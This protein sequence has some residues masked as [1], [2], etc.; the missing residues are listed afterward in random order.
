MSTNIKTSLLELSPSKYSLV[1]EP[2]SP[3]FGF[4]VGNSL[5]RI[6]LSAI[7]GYAVTRIKINDDVTHEY[8]SIP[9]IVED[10]LDIVL[11]LKLLRAKIVNGDEKSTII[12]KK[13][14]QC[15]VY[16]KDFMENNKAI[17]I[18]NPDLFICSV[19]KDGDVTIEIDIEKGVGYR[20]ID[21]VNLNENINPQNILVDALFNPVTNV[22]ME[23]ENIRV[24]DMTNY[25]KIVLNFD[26]DGTVSAK[27]VVD[28]SFNLYIDTI[29]NIQSSFGA[30][31]DMLEATES[32]SSAKKKVDPD[33]VESEFDDMEATAK[34]KIIQILTKNEIFT[35]E[36]LLAK[37]D[38]LE[39][40]NG[41]DEKMLLTIREYISKIS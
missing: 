13:K 39:E 15:D 5:R 37:K 11:N 21:K 40:L 3:G 38:T 41:F 25:N 26:I 9:G 8:Q 1:I 35:K 27:E 18:T 36:E 7:P 2:L 20:A 6:L 19:D 4:T 17:V 33:S 12:I 22:A 16:A 28:Y 34:K 29:K 23:V 32:S 31:V 14:G 30:S 24:G 10:V